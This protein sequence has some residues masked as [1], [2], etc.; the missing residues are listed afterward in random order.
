M[1][2]TGPQSRPP[3]SALDL[4]AAVGRPVIHGQADITMGEGGITEASEEKEE[5]QEE[6][7]E[8]MDDEMKEDQARDDKDEAGPTDDSKADYKN[9]AGGRDGDDVPTR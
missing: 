6:K 2:D 9:D 7:E 4:T 3:G 5:E 8:P 1:E